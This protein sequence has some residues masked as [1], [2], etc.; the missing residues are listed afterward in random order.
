[1]WNAATGTM[2]I[3]NCEDFK[4]RPT[5]FGEG[6][7]AAALG[8]KPIESAFNEN[9]EIIKSHTHSRKPRV[10]AIVLIHEGE[11]DWRS[12]IE[13]AISSLV[14]DSSPSIVFLPCLLGCNVLHTC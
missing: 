6:G 12:L 11:D 5:G 8:F 2:R 7:A 9:P 14:E 10:V 1:M 4:L 3:V 13:V